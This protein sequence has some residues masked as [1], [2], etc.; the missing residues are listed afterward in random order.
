[1]TETTVFHQWSKI[2]ALATVFYGIR[3]NIFLLFREVY[4]PR[5]R[6]MRERIEERRNA[7][8]GSDGSFISNLVARTPFILSCA[9]LYAGLIMPPYSSGMLFHLGMIPTVECSSVALHIYK[10]LVS[11]TWLGFSIGALGD[12]NKTLVKAYK[13]ADHLVTSGIFKVLRHPN[14]T[15][16]V[17]GWTSSFL[18]SIVAVIAAIKQFGIASLSKETIF[19]KLVLPHSLGLMGF[20]G[21]VFVLSAATLNLE[22]RQEEKYSALEEYRE[23]IKTSWKG[24]SLR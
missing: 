9:L 14:Y 3:L 21:I 20:I 13:G 8:D 19:L 4:I 1:L 5:F 10:A 12:L 15:G 6:H 24:F 11:M 16:E 2:H 18:A 7:K 23:W 17:I 22:K